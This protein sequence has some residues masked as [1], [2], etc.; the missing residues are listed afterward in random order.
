VVATVIRSVDIRLP[1]CGREMSP[2]FISPGARSEQYVIFHSVR[3]ITPETADHSMTESSV[4][5]SNYLDTGGGER[6]V[7]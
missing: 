4:T 7:G 6:F 2:G 1:H 3:S 5:I